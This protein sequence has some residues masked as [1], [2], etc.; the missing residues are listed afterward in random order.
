MNLKGNQV[1]ANKTA[2]IRISMSGPKIRLT[3][4][5]EL[6]CNIN[7]FLQEPMRNYLLSLLPDFCDIKFI[8]PNIECHLMQIPQFIT[9]IISLKLVFC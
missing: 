8:D 3:D 6:I 5:N 4:S 7:H 1:L 2:A 9:F